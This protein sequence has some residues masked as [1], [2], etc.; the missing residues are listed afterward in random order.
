[1]K[2]NWELELAILKAALPIWEEFVFSDEVYW[3]LHLD[4]TLPI[5]PEEKPRLSAGRLCLALN[6]LQMAMRSDTG[7]KRY[8]SP[9][10]ELF[11]Q[12]IDRWPANWDKKI[13]TEIPVRLRQ[14][15]NDLNDLRKKENHYPAIFERVIKLRFML[16]SM[17][18][19]INTESQKNYQTNLTAID[20]LIGTISEPAP[21][22][23][24]PEYAPF[25]DSEIYWYLYR[26]LK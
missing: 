3:P 5:K 18:D 24:Q 26:T 9:D 11:H 23:W 4:H 15:T 21:F 7:L 25:F 16:G 22:I 10:F 17:F 1:M 6:V 13:E 8:I 19:C 12:M 2:I 20:A 14:I